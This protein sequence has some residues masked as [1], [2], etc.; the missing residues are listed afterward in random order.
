M[1]FTARNHPNKTFHDSAFG[2]APEAS[3]KLTSISRLPAWRGRYSKGTCVCVCVYVCMCVYV[4]IEGTVLKMHIC[5]EG[6]VLKKGYHGQ[7]SA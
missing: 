6:T 1:S 7:M 2:D 4:C 5:M 3:T